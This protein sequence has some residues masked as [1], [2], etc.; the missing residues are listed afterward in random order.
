MEFFRL[1]MGISFSW[2]NLVY[3]FNLE[4]L[5]LW[6]TELKIKLIEKDMAYGALL[7]HAPLFVR[8]LQGK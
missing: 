7:F 5:S 2:L 4:A 1:C 8:G 3:K 6:M